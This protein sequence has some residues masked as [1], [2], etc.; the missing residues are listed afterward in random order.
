LGTGVG[1]TVSQ[2]KKLQVGQRIAFTTYAWD[3]DT[4]TGAFESR[5][6]VV[7]RVAGAYHAYMPSENPYFEVRC[8]GGEILLVQR[9]EITAVLSPAS[10]EVEAARAARERAMSPAGLR[11]RLTQAAPGLVAAWESYAETPLQHAGPLKARVV[12]RLTGRSIKVTTTDGTWAGKYHLPDGPLCLNDERNRPRAVDALSEIG[13]EVPLMDES[14]DGVPDA[15]MFS[16]AGSWRIAAVIP[17]RGYGD[18]PTLGHFIED[19][20]RLVSHDKLFLPYLERLVRRHGFSVERAEVCTPDEAFDLQDTVAKLENAIR[21]LIVSERGPDSTNVS[22]RDPKP[23]RRIT[24]AVREFVPA[25]FADYLEEEGFRRQNS[26]W[27]RDQDIPEEVKSLL[28][29]TVHDAMGA[30]SAEIQSAMAA[31]STPLQLPTASAHVWTAVSSLAPLH[32]PLL[33]ALAL[34]TAEPDWWKGQASSAETRA[35]ARETEVAWEDSCETNNVRFS[36]VHGF[37]FPETD[38]PLALLVAASFLRDHG[39]AVNSDEELDNT[40]RICGCAFGDGHLNLWEVHWAGSTGYCPGCVSL[41]RH[42]AFEDRGVDDPWMDASVWALQEL[43]A[44]EFGGPPSREQVE[45]PLG[46]ANDQSRDRALVLRALLPTGG[47]QLGSVMRPTRKLYSWSDWLR[48]AR[49]LP[50]E[51]RTSRGV[52]SVANDG[53]RCLSMLERSI[54]DFMSLHG[55]VHEQEPSYPYDPTLNAT[56]LRADWR[57][58]DGAFV[59]AFGLIGNA[60]YDSKVERKRALTRKHGIR[61]VEVVQRD[62]KRLPEVFA[63]WLTTD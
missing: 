21:L 50:D 63:E 35:Q 19:E 25:A 30:W 59:E 17:E 2:A 40:C 53:H 52:V 31:I 8:D 43:A 5:V 32:A 44:S 45:A 7:M 20:G 6:G 29:K 4:K 1:L 61:L 28:P 38:G 11:R 16:G 57:L 48:L 33:A 60:S 23:E 12:S 42:G 24:D 18:A 55:I 22:A 3:Q 10:P 47:L 58:A 54:D 14:M 15:V 9:R 49:L 27:I 39:P 34:R 62:L 37:G 46:T 51:L 36:R 13:I 56:G 41:G 26:W